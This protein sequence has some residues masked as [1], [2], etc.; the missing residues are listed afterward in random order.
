MSLW[1][2]FFIAVCLSMDAFAVAVCKGLSMQKINY[3]HSVVIALFFGG[4]QALMPLIGWLV[5][6]RFAHYIEAFDHWVIFAL[7]A[8]IG[9]KMIFDS[10]KAESCSL[11]G[12]RLDIRELFLLAIATSLDALAVGVTLALLPSVRILPSVGLIGITTFVLSLLGVAVGN[13]FG[14]RYQQKAEFLGGVALVLIGGK[15]L[16][17]H[18]SILPF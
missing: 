3:R 14:S 5:S 18:L 7:L 16:L 11:C 12:D 4:F 9:G 17:E 6:S 15:I 8:M 2:L 10:R 1:D 13:R